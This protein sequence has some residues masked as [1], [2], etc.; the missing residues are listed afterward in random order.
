MRKLIKESEFD[1]VSI[2]GVKA[3]LEAEKV[4][5]ANKNNC[6]KAGNGPCDTTATQVNGCLAMASSRGKNGRWSYFLSN[7][8]TC[9]SVEKEALSNC[10]ASKAKNCKIEIGQLDSEYQY[11]VEPL[12]RN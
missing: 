4:H 6:E 11:S 5:K 3:K 9:G 7:S 2:C 8:G 12:L 10:R 1:A